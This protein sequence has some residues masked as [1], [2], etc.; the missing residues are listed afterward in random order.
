MLVA[1]F[2][3]VVFH[4]AIALRTHPPSRNLF[5]L[6][7]PTDCK[8]VCGLS[9]EF[10]TDKFLQ[11]KEFANITVNGD[12]ETGNYRL[13]TESAQKLLSYVGLSETSYECTRFNK[14]WKPSIRKFIVGG[15]YLPTYSFRFL[16]TDYKY[17]EA[18][19]Y[20]SIGSP[21]NIPGRCEL[22]M[23]RG[24]LHREPSDNVTIIW[25][26]H[27]FFLAISHHLIRG[28]QSRFPMAVRVI[29][30]LFGFRVMVVILVS[31]RVVRNST[32]FGC[33]QRHSTYQYRSALNLLKSTSCRTYFPYSPC[34]TLKKC[35]E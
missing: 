21:R 1:L 4:C 23:S 28:W 8:K 34:G 7:P 27:E 24:I 11:S 22:R 10:N 35:Q 16:G 33:L 5:R 17:F 14:L 31:V 32:Y 18:G 6:K 20:A 30:V 29:H 3:I 25:L 15:Q 2:L 19:K 9:N 26:A 12:C 13:W